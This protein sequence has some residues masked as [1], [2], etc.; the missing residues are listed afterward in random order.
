ME[1][2]ARLEAA[3]SIGAG[4]NIK[5]PLW[6]RNYDKVICEYEERKIQSII[7]YIAKSSNIDIS[8]WLGKEYNR[9][10]YNYFKKLGIDPFGEYGEFH[11]TVVNAD[12]FVHGL[13]YSLGDIEEVEEGYR[14]IIK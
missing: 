5:L 12:F 11:T 14:V 10:A 13:E 4:L 9:E 2:S 3:L 8:E 1:S 6:K 7:T